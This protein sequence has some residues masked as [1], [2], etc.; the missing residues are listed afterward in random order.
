M[1]VVVVM[2]SAV[3]ELSHQ[4]SSH[5]VLLSAHREQPWNQT[6]PTIGGAVL[7]LDK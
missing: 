6:T 4:E 5:T 3:L 1:L 7:R 2:D